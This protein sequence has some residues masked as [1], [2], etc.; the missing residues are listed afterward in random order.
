VFSA[1]VGAD[2]D[3]LGAAI[4]QFALDRHAGAIR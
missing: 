2:D 3:D 1:A 4:G